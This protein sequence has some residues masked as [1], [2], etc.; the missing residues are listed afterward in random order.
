MIFFS[1]YLVGRLLFSY[2]VIG[3]RP[4]RPARAAPP[5][6]RRPA[7]NS[8]PIHAPCSSAAVG[9]RHCLFG[10]YNALAIRI[11]RTSRTFSQCVHVIECG[12]LV[13]VLDGFSFSRSGSRR[14]ERAPGRGSRCLTNARRA[15]LLDL[16]TRAA[17]APAPAPTAASR[18]Q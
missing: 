10:R 1:D 18:E 12:G 15:Q 13:V 9:R 14:H 8:V 7:A 16:L 5:A 11:Y 2:L 17:S 4:P 3:R 6:P